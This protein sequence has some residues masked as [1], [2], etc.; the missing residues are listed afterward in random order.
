MIETPL[1]H[2]ITVHQPKINP[3]VTS[4]GYG[5][6]RYNSMLAYKG[7]AL[8][9]VGSHLRWVDI[10]KRQVLRDLQIGSCQIF[11]VIEN[12][13]YILAVNFDGLLTLLLK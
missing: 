10:K 1:L 4:I 6:P 11:Q 5:N 8:L 7:G 12:A 3:K 2:K 13:K 9:T